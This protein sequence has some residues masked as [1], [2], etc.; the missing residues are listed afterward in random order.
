MNIFKEGSRYQ[1]N[2][3]DGGIGVVDCDE[4]V[5]RGGKPIYRIDGS[6]VYTAGSNAEYV[7]E[8]D[9]LTATSIKDGNILFL[10]KLDNTSLGS[11]LQGSD[12]QSNENSR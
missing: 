6:D 8:L 9:G 5:R 12:A 3:N 11:T 1:V 2:F 7:A 4:F 10:L